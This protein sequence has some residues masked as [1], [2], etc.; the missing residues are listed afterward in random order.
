M[1]LKGH[2][3]LPASCI[4]LRIKTLPLPTLLCSNDDL[5]DYSASDEE[6]SSS[7]EESSS[8]EASEWS[9]RE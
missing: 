4:A 9:G 7:E 5:P 3:A 1:G 2:T 6:S 8:E